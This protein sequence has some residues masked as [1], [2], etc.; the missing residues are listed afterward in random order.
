[1]HKIAA[2][3]YEA[4]GDLRSS[5]ASLGEHYYLLGNLSRATHQLELA[6]RAPSSNDY[7]ANARL[8]ARLEQMRGELND[9]ER[10]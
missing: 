9:R 2:R 10:Q 3:A 5:H 1:M 7:Y 6:K 4:L 8:E